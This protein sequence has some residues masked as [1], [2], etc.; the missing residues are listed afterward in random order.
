MRE[1]SLCKELS[2]KLAKDIG[3]TPVSFG[4]V[5][6]T[7]KELLT[8]Y[9]VNV[10]DEDGGEIRKVPIW[11]GEA[12]GG[13]GI[14]C[15]LLAGL[16]TDPNKLEFAFVLGFKDFGGEFQTEG[17]RISFHYD[18]ANDTDPG[19]ILMKVG[20]RWLPISLAQR[21]QLVLGFE[22]MIQDGVQWQVSPSI[23]EELRKDLAEIIE[24]DEKN[25]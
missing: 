4:K 17:L 21:L 10:S 22:T 7:H 14:S 25:S 9:S 2:L 23:P 24:V 6:L 3:A 19:T 15:G 8:T 18:W 5:S 20:D 13:D 1:F 12:L 11:Y 16:D